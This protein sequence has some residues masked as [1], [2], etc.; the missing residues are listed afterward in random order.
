MSATEDFAVV[1]HTMTD[2]SAATLRAGRRERLN[3]AFEAVECPPLA[4]HHNLK[5][6]VVVVAA[7]FALS[8][9]VSFRLI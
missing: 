8:H 6:F 2:D 5:G 1:L 4:T 3:R 7:D 9:V